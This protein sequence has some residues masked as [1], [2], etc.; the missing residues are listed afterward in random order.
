MRICIFGVYLF[1]L[2]LVVFSLGVPPSD[3]PLCVLMFILALLGLALAR[4]ESRAWRA[5]WTAGLVIAIV[6]GAFEVVAAKRIAA[7]RLHSE[8]RLASYSQVGETAVANIAMLQ[9]ASIRHGSER[10]DQRAIASSAAV[11]ATPKWGP[12][13]TL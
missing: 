3:F 12:G 10:S 9:R 1:P 13:A 4:H 6:C 5:I 11:Q 7:R 2:W 8:Q